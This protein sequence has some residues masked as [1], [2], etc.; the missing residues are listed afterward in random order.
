MIF[1]K[2][3]FGDDPLLKKKSK[4]VKKIT[5]KIWELLDDM[6]ETMVKTDGIGLAS[7]QIGILKRI[8]VIDIGEGLI[9]LIN[10]E[11]VEQFG[12]QI[13]QEGCLSIPRKVG[14]VNRPEFVKVTG[15]DR[16]GN[17][18]VHEATGL[19]ATAFCHEIDHL[20]GILFVD[21]CT[22]VYEVDDDE[23]SEADT[24][25]DEHIYD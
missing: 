12:N 10:P 1:R 21:R 20:D 18:V 17:Q 11:I 22:E 3:R 15:L 6:A 8:I 9:E 25:D 2:L 24:Y 7:P 19:L 23:N 14:Y 16:H 4:E 13:G 5:P